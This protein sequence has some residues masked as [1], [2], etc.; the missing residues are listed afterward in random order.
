MVYLPA[1]LNLTDAQVKKAL[2]GKSFRISKEQIGSGNK[3]VLLHPSQ[4]RLVSMAQQAGKGCMV[5]LAPGEIVS[6]QESSIEGTGFFGDVWDGIK[7]AYNWTKK[8]IVETPIYQSVVKPIVKGAI[9]VASAPFIAAD[10][11][12]LLGKAKD[13]IGKETG[14][15]GLKNKKKRI[16]NK[17]DG[18]SF[19]LS[20]SSFK[21]N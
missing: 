15:Y 16:K 7:S 10:P 17:T 1:R 13:A 12:G 5:H 20:G 3:I 6:T 9:D 21:L 14:A 2:N 11:T 8:N 4:H 19:K 18:S